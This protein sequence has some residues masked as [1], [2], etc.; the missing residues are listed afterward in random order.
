MSQIESKTCLVFKELS[1]DSDHYTYID[2]IFRE[3]PEGCKAL[4]THYLRPK[5]ILAPH[6]FSDGWVIHELLHTMGWNDHEHQR[7]D[8]DCYVEVHF[9]SK[10]I[11]VI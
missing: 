10:Y 8:R 4:D 3:E 1:Q 2:I 9:S 5:A 7:E 6:C 11:V